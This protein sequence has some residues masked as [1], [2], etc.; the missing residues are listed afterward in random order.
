MKKAIFLVEDIADG[1]V[2]TLL[3]KQ[4]KKLNT[5][6]AQQGKSM[7]WLSEITRLLYNQSS[8]DI[9]FVKV[10]DFIKSGSIP[11]D[12][13]VFYFISCFHNLDVFSLT[14]LLLID[15][16]VADFLVKHKIPIVIDSSMEICDH[17]H[18]SY[19]LL[20]ELHLLKN[21]DYFRG[22]HTLDFYIVG[23]TEQSI[24]F[25]RPRSINTYHTV[26]PGPFF[27]YNHTG[28]EF[29]KSIIDNRE[30]IINKVKNQKI[31][32]DTLVWQALS[33]KTRINRGL[34]FM[35]AASEGLDAVGRYSRLLPG[36]QAFVEECNYL[37]IDIKSIPYCNNNLNAL[38][39]ISTI[40]GSVDRVK[41]FNDFKFMVWVSLETF[42]SIDSKTVYKTTSFLTEK[43]AMAIASGS[44]FIPLGGHRIGKQLLDLRFKEFEKLKFPTEPSLF[45]EVDYVVDC[46]KY[47]ASLSTSQKQ[48]LYDSWKDT[49]IYNYDH[50]RNIDIKR[51]YLSLLNKSRLQAK[52]V[53]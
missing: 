3:E 4:Y 48:N 29:N 35:K 52:A 17:Q 2:Y 10:S 19:K 36:K 21:V 23:S 47:I 37:N 30:E 9:K 7:M 53:A 6:L 45:K 49:I 31:T 46:I 39:V 42:S 34:F 20:E 16:E 22:L 8:N 51:T 38:D 40:D 14:D 32:D 41:Q 43:T 11:Q 13:D 5:I 26:F 15:P 33:N 18:S 12:R 1:K 27:Q 24:Q 25:N 50:Y 44:A 28:S